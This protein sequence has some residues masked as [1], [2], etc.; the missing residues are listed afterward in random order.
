MKNTK[1]KIL[2]T[3]RDLFNTYGY[4]KT[5]MDLIAKE[6][7]VTK[8]TI[9]SY[10]KDKE[11]LINHFLA[12]Q[13]NQIRDIINQIYTEDKPLPEKINKML[14]T[15]FEYR[16]NNKF[17]VNLGKSARLWGGKSK[18]LLMKLNKQIENEIYLKL[19][20]AEKK[21]QIKGDNL[22]LMAFIIYRIYVSVLFEW[23]DDI[24]K[25]KATKEIMEFLESGIIK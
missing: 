16:E 12:E 21:G 19:V 24:D 22:R 10:F 18:D 25:E 20:D 3:A 6:A 1:E 14:L 5:S 2:D 9:Y 15:I 4:S 17:I 11:T 23:E 7:G 13:M 8:K